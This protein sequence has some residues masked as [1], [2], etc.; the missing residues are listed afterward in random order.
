MSAIL[1]AIF[2]SS[3][4]FILYTYFGYPILLIIA[5]KLRGKPVDKKSFTPR[6]TMIIAAYNEERT[7]RDKLENALS[8][9][10]PKDKFE[11]IV[12]SD[13]SSDRTD[14]IVREFSSRGVRLIQMPERGGKARALNAAVPEAHGEIIVFSDARQLY[15]KKAVRELVNNFNDGTVGGVSGEL[16]LINQNGGSVG[17]GVGMYWR[18][19]KLLRKKE[20]QIYSTSGATG[21]IYAIRKELYRPIHD[22]TI[23]DDVVIPM[24]IVLSGHRVVF[25]ERARA[26]DNVAN[27]AREELARKI[28]TLCGNYQAFSRMSELFNPFKNKV[29]LQLVSHKVFRLFVPF[30]LFFMLISSIFLSP[31]LFYRIMLALQIFMYISAAIG[32]YLSNVGSPTTRKKK[33]TEA[34]SSLI[35]RLFGIPYALVVLNY[36]AV[37][38]LYRFITNKQRPAWEKAVEY[39]EE[40]A[41]QGR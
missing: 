19:E 16:H 3:F 33:D 11:I 25:E 28:R 22:D 6:V 9:D 18:Y 26:Y 8:I 2:W 39:R 21:A 13:G 38:G 15:D 23:V 36:A 32:H 24:N 35:G 41:L 37:A 7:I 5:A 40:D 30:A 17:E 20:S 14:D 34:K 10:Y 31:I 27:T 1:K 4:L 12:A 29:F